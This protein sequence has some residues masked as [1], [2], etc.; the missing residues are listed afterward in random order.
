[1]KDLRPGK[2]IIIKDVS[3]I[4]YIPPVSGVGKK[5]CPLA[6]DLAFGRQLTL[7]FWKVVVQTEIE[8]DI[9]ELDGFA[10]EIHELRIFLANKVVVI[11]EK[12][13]YAVMLTLKIT[14]S[15]YLLRTCVVGKLI[16][17]HRLNGMNIPRYY[18]SDKGCSRLITSINKVMVKN[19]LQKVRES[20]YFGLMTSYLGIVNIGDSGAASIFNCISDMLKQ[21]NLDMQRFIGFGSDGC[22]VMADAYG[23]GECATQ[24][25]TIDKLVNKVMSSLNQKFQEKLID[26]TM[27]GPLCRE[28]IVKLNKYYISDEID[29]NGNPMDNKSYPCIPDGGSK[30]GFLHALRVS[31]KGDAYKTMQLIRSEDG[32]DLQEAMQFQISFTFALIANIRQRL[33]DTGILSK[34]QA[35]E[36][37]KFYGRH[38]EVDGVLVKGIVDPSAFMEEYLTWKLLASKEWKGRNFIDMWSIIHS[39]TGWAE[40]FPN[41]LRV[42][43]IGMVQCV[44]I[45]SCE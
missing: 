21:W 39:Q 7:N 18:D 37:A 26:I 42:G 27:V 44:S 43:E 11:F 19:I 2:K 29:L 34:M 22:N 23:D 1:M 40:S 3:K 28:T 25:M 9:E 5:K 24:C 14:R 33:Q 12:V 30:D 20:L 38:L 8:N 4:Y 41:L 16:E 13:P 36:L 15:L 17:L 31:V 10:R 32:S 45:A 35:R 6:T